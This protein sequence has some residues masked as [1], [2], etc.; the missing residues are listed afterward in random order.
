M[1]ET[2]EYAPQRAEMIEKQLRR[3]LFGF[4]HA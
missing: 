4:K 2:K 3:V 1:L